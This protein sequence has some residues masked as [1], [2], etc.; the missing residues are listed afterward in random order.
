M[1]HDMQWSKM[2]VEGQ[3]NKEAPVLGA[4]DAA[5]LRML[6]EGEQAPYSRDRFNLLRL[7]DEL[8]RATVVPQSEL[9]PDV[10]RMRSRVRLKDVETGMELNYVL[11]YP[12]QA[13]ALPGAISVVAPVG[14]ALLGN[15][16]GAEIEWEVPKG[17]RRRKVL[18]VHPPPERLCGQRVV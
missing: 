13:G 14:T 15:A 1:A 18:A 6:V 16:V 8:D 4:D 7:E 17:S 12:H 2:M 5:R 11:V 9:P 3:L 10:V